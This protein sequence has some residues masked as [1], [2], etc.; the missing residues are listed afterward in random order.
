VTFATPNAFSYLLGKENRDKEKLIARGATSA[1][2]FK[3]LGS[4]L[5]AFA[6]NWMSKNTEFR[7]FT[8]YSDP[9][10]GE[11]GTIY[12]SLNFIF[13]GSNFGTKI[14]LFDPERPEKG[15]FS[16]REARKLSSYKRIAKKMGLQWQ[17]SWSLNGSIRWENMR[18]DVALS[19]KTEVKNYI[20]KCEK[21]T[22]SKKLKW[23]YIRGKDKRETKHL[24]KI[25][26]EVNP[27][28]IQKDGKIGFPYPKE[29][30]RGK[31]EH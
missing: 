2:A 30:L 24:L 23:V 15:W 11:L 1:I 26:K 5:N 14:L 10:A 19:L 29:E 17:N 16:D 8:A 13:L 21:R 25:F 20:Q 9:E 27:K 28:L 6:I 7:V 12:K 22:P 31:N 4:A 18:E 3:H